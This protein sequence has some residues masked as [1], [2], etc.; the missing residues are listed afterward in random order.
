[1]KIPTHSI[2]WRLQLWYG[3]FLFIAIGAFSLTAFKLVSMNQMRAIDRDIRRIERRFILNIFKD[4]VILSQLPEKKNTPPHEVFLDYIYKHQQSLSSDFLGRIKGMLPDPYYFACAQPKGHILLKSDNLPEQVERVLQTREPSDGKRLG[5]SGFRESTHQSPD[6]L[7]FIIGRSIETEV[8]EMNRLAISFAFSA[9]AFWTL[10]LFGGWWIAG[11][12]LSPI[13]RISNTATRIA[14]GNLKERIISTGTKSEL[15]Q[16]SQVLNNT[17]ERLHQA[18]TRQQQFTANASHEL[19]NPLTILLSE[20][21]RMR[22]RERTVSEYRDSFDLCHD[23]ALRMK[24]QVEDLLLLARQDSLQKPT[25]QQPC[26]LSL[27]I[28]KSITELSLIATEKELQ[29]HTELQPTS[30][31]ADADTLSILINNLIGNAI[32]HHQGK[33]TVSVKCSSIEKQICL[34]VSDDGPGIAE[35]DLPHIFE[36]F[37]RAESSR[38]QTNHSGLGLSIV[39][40]IVQSHGGQIEVDSHLGKGSTFK[41]YLPLREV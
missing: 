33:G 24:K 14:Q 25:I 6:G 11:K 16:L 39:Q 2:R 10:G 40:T 9:L 20:T 27:L 29:M 41:I 36:R 21:Q 3:A 15:D 8:N 22:K 28:E 13:A 18:L 37:Y 17:F 30:L 31:N 35:K 12:A 5:N 1:M 26:D 32:E 38:S 4:E 34:E 7:R 23:A 19:R